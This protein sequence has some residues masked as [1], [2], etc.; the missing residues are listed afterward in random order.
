MLGSCGFSRGVHYWEYKIDRYD[1]HPDPAF[2][3]ARLDTTK[4]AMLGNYQLGVVLSFQHSY[5]I[6]RA[7]FIG[8]F[9][10]FR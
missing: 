8:V 4:D 5:A 2:G 9:V 10:Y 6:C 3:V 1:N 7:K